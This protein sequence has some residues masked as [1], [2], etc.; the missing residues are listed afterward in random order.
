MLSS[1]TSFLPSA[2]QINISTHENNN[3]TTLEKT[4]PPHNQEDAEAYKP[5]VDEDVGVNKDTS[6]TK[7]KALNEVCSSFVSVF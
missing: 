3:D 6:T 1:L 2:F 5:S 4:S 7:S